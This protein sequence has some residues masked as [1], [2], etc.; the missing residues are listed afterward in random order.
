MRRKRIKWNFGDVFGAKLPN[1]ELA[2]L[3]AINSFM[4]NIVYVALTDKKIS[5]IGVDLP[6]LTSDDIISLI[7]ITRHE[8]DFA[9]DFILLGT[10]QLI[11]DKSSFK[12]EQFKNIGY[13]GAISYD[14]GLAID[15]LAA[16]HKQAPWDDW[17]DPNY[18]DEYLVSLEK[19]PKEL[20]YLKSN[21]SNQM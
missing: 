21:P 4:T 9:E 11:A 15:F 17:Y 8:L 6:I 3:Q 10:Q 20:I 16:Y 19:K 12:N 13:V 14:A 18:L 2:L 1:G 7:A 5:T